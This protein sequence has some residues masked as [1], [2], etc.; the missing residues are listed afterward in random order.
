MTSFLLLSIL[1]KVALFS[2]DCLVL[3]SEELSYS[4]LLVFFFFSNE[5]ELAKFDFFCYQVS[6][7]RCQLSTELFISFRNKYLIRKLK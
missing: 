3:V 7:C 5:N 6:A 1:P 4:L 2:E